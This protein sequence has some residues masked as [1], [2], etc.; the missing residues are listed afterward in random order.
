MELKMIISKE[1]E[2]STLVIL[3]IEDSKLDLDRIMG[4]LIDLGC[5]S[6]NIHCVSTELDAL[7]IISKHRWNHVF[8]DLGLPDGHGSNI[9]REFGSNNPNVPITIISS[10]KDKQTIFDAIRQGAIGYLFKEREDIEIKIGIRNALQGGAAIDPSISKRILDEYRN[11]IKIDNK[12]SDL[13]LS[14]REYEILICIS[15]GLTNKEIASRLYI[16]RYT[17]ETHIKSI[18]KK[19][20]ISSRVSATNIVREI[21]SR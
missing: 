17:V 14:N 7:S 18:Y 9:I 2:F 1:I 15:H 12:P 13:P 3:V 10:W 11:H 16:S 21:N 20:S 4:M 19:L 8:L 5:Q 6:M